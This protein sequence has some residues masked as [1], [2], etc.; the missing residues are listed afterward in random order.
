[1]ATALTPRSGAFDLAEEVLRR[2]F[3]EQVAN[4]PGGRRISRCLQCGTCTGSCPV[5]YAMD[6]SPRE[7]IARFRAG[8]I[9]SLLESRTI[10]LCASCYAC[11]TRCPAGIKVTDIMYALKRMTADRHLRRRSFPPFAMAEGFV[12]MVRL[13]GRN[14]EPWLLALYYWRTGFRGMLGNLGM[15]TRLFLRGR[16]P[17]RPKRI[18]G[19]E[20][21]RRILRRAEQLEIRYEDEIAGTPLDEVGYGTL[22]AAPPRTAAAQSV[23]A[24]AG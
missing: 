6:L 12:T 13:F 9:R 11:T 22:A 18:K 4:I 7:V 5:A 20:D 15:A 19:L 14:S 2:E 10:W 23:G 21:L 24:A 16:L 17:V 8:D 1:V 3:L